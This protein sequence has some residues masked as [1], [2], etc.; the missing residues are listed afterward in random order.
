[1]NPV[2]PDVATE[3]GAAATK[4]FTALG[5]VDAARRAEA[6]P[7]IRS[8]EVAD[9]LT[10]LGIGELDPRDDADSLAAAAALCEAAGRVGLP[11]PVPSAL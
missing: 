7:T 9:A 2:L 4:A 10:A 11:Y 8:A 6:D 3:F 1:M 5:G